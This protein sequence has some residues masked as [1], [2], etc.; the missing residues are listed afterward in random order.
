MTNATKVSKPAGKDSKKKGEEVVVII[1][2][3]IHT[4]DI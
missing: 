1:Q 2:E 3:Q 4:D